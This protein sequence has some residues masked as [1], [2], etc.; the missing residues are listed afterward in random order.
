MWRGFIFLHWRR[1]ASFTRSFHGCRSIVRHFETHIDTRKEPSAE[2]LRDSKVLYSMYWRYLRFGRFS[3]F[4]V[5][6]SVIVSSRASD[7]IR[8]LSHLSA[9]GWPAFSSTCSFLVLTKRFVY[10]AVPDGLMRTVWIFWIDT[11]DDDNGPSS[12]GAE[13]QSNRGQNYRWW[14]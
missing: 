11:G 8:L 14:A 6:H 10:V 4:L 7:S 9:T 13:N 12:R 1:N 5:C 3:D 2:L